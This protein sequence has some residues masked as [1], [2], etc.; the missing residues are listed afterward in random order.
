ME[1]LAVT[2]NSRSRIRDKRQVEVQIVVVQ[3]PGENLSEGK[4]R[5]TH[6]AEEM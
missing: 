3:I 2:Q 1:N 4:T 5:E 6:K